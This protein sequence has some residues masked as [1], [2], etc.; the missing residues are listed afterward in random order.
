MTT[1]IFD[2]AGAIV[3]QRERA[4]NFVPPP[5]QKSAEAPNVVA[6]SLLAAGMIAA[7]GRAHTPEEAMAVLRQVLEIMSV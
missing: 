2:L 5:R 7:T 4:V 1:T 6:A 3:N